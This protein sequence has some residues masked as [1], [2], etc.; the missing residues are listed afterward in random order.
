MSLLKLPFADV[1]YLLQCF[2]VALVFLSQ[3]AVTLKSTR[4]KEILWE[5]PR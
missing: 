3:T 5:K 2:L 4:V 1:N